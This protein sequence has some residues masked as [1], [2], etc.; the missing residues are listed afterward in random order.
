MTRMQVLDVLTFLP[1]QILTKVDRASMAVGLEARVPLLDHRVVAFALGLRRE[2]KIRA[3]VSKGLLDQ[4]LYRHVPPELVERPKQGFSVPLAHWL[5]GPLREWAEELLD[6]R[7]LR[8]Q[9]FFEVQPIRGMWH[10]HRTGRPDWST[11]LWNIL[12]SQSW[13]HRY[14]TAT[15]RPDYSSSYRP[16]PDQARCPACSSRPLR[17]ASDRSVPLKRLACRLGSGGTPTP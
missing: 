4:V 17:R 15:T 16:N 14:G 2:L 3:G 12:M 5:R 1:D 8:S 10:A 9:S 11:V 6:L 7:R 13:L